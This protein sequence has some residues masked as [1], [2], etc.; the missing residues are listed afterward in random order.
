MLMGIAL[1]AMIMIVQVAL[2]VMGG[3][4]PPGLF[5]LCVVV[6]QLGV[7]T[8]VL[9]N[10]ARLRP[11][12]RNNMETI[13]RAL[14]VG[15]GAILAGAVLAAAPFILSLG[16]AA[17]KRFGWALANREGSSA[18]W[19]SLAAG[20]VE[21]AG[22]ALW[23]VGC[24]IVAQTYLRRLHGCPPPRLGSLIVVVPASIGVAAL[25]ALA[26]KMMTLVG[27]AE[28]GTAI[29]QSPFSM[30]MPAL[31]LV[32]VAAALAGVIGMYRLRRALR[33]FCGGSPTG[34]CP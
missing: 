27:Q 3:W 24:F 4:E 10:P 11:L 19:L 13:R 33:R 18:E 5:T 9:A 20:F 22:W 21:A 6:S 1:L 34:V 7:I 28:V 25:S 23:G 14:N 8:L 15:C 29:A 32:S 26:W 2:V 16:T 31:F 17:A 30:A 12:L